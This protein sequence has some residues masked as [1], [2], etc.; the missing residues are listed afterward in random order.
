MFGFLMANIAEEDDPTKGIFLFFHR[1]FPK[2]AACFPLTN[3]NGVCTKSRE[4]PTWC[5]CLSYI[6]KVIGCF[7]TF[8]G[9]RNG[10]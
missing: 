3:R 4:A 1:D 9:Y 8:Y 5:G 2:R 6:I 10:S 7:L